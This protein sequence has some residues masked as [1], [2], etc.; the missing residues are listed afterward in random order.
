MDL[1]PARPRDLFSENARQTRNPY[2]TCLDATTVE[3]LRL[4]GLM[5][6]QEFRSVRVVV[7]EEEPSL[8]SQLAMFLFHG[9]IRGLIS[10]QDDR[11]GPG[12]RL[13]HEREVAVTVAD[14]QDPPCAV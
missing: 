9:P 7:A 1:V 14:E 12:A 3:M 4:H 8:R 6:F 5:L 2:A 13:T 11:F 10:E